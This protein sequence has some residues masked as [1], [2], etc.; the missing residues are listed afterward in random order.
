MKVLLVANTSDETEQSLQKDG[1]PD[2][3]MMKYWWQEI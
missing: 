2:G 1:C 3:G